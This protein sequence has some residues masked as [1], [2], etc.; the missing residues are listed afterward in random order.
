MRS[1]AVIFLMWKK[2]SK[3]LADEMNEH[4][5]RFSIAAGPLAQSTAA[6]EMTENP[7]GT[8]TGTAAVE[9]DAL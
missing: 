7:T 4:H 9:N 5:R 1:L 6:L 3:D 2:K 8:S